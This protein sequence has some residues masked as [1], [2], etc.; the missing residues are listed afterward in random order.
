M[1]DARFFVTNDPAPVSEAAQIA[2]AALSPGATGVIDRAASL[3]E[4]DLSGAV[5]FIE[6]REAA[7]K[8]EGRA[9][10][11]A[12]TTP[13][14]ASA[15]SA[16][17]PVG[18]M[19]APR[20]GFARIA[21]RLHAERPSSA[22]AGIDPSAEIGEGARIHETAVIAAG[23]TIGEGAV[24]DAY[25]VIGPGVVIGA[26]SHVGAGATIAHCIMGARAAILPGA[27]IGQAGFGFVAG[28]D[29]PVRVPQ[30]GRVMMG[31]DVEIGANTTID[32]GALG[33]TAI[34]DGV[35]IDNLVQ[36]GH[37][38]RIGRFSILAAHVGI[39]GS[40]VIGEGALLGGK[41]GVADHVTIGDGAQIAAGAGV[42]RDIGPGEKWGGL[43]AR[44]FRTWFRE[45][46]TLAK[47]ASK[48]KTE[49]D[50]D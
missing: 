10:G 23:A 31:D 24:I 42:M 27:R 49:E 12:L 36:I 15:L 14:L 21:A 46:A 8:L 29:G 25:A 3:D 9:V 5:V 6:N 35:K 50:G 37:N 16:S 18:V 30:L 4:G 41:V 11:L 48:K 17:G 20:L 43:P 45:T 2:G 13:A 32:R 38:V 44:P 26:Q 47:L 34:G 33:D 19:D 39:S 1:P 22:A 28:P 40:T 7:A